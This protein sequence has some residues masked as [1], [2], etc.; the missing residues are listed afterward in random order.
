MKELLLFIMLL[1][2]GLSIAMVFILG[3]YIRIYRDEID[4]LKIEQMQ[5]RKR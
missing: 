3:R 5:A 1:S 4:I 2:T